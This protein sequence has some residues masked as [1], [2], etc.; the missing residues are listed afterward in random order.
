MTGPMSLQAHAFDT[1]IDAWVES[2]VAKCGANFGELLR[3]LP[4]IYPTAVI[5][6]LRRLRDQGRAS[7]AVVNALQHQAVTGERTATR[8]PVDGLPL[9]HPL[10]YEWRFTARSAQRLLHLAEEFSRPGDTVLL[11]GTPGVAAYA[12]TQTIGRRLLFLGE[13]NPVTAAVR[14]LSLRA[15]GA[16]SVQFCDMGAIAPEPATVVVIDPP[17]YLDFIRPILA[18]AAAGCRPGGHVFLSL[19]PEGTRATAVND[20]GKAIKY[21]ERLG[22]TSVG[23]ERSGLTY[24]S[25]FF[26]RN[27][28]AAAGVKGAPPDW[29]CGDLV[30]LRKAH[31]RAVQV[32]AHLVNKQR[33]RE[34]AIESMRLLVRMDHP[35]EL[36]GKWELRPVVMGEVLPTVSRRDPRRRRAT[37][38]TSGNRAFTT[39][40]PDLVLRAAETLAVAHKK[41]GAQA[42]SVVS[43]A[44]RNAIEA[45]ARELRRIV[46][47]EDR[48]ARSVANQGDRTCGPGWRSISG[49]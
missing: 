4:G 32:H 35:F 17:W 41:S 8:C 21:A 16:M 48:E 42:S 5:A 39:F 23:S 10:N 46:D 19:P 9:P 2:E 43:M 7:P 15:G 20:C 30:I 24:A 36:T 1:R 12:T 11:L 33:W 3:K 6:S 34:I 25:P 49:A 28:L 38:W 44:E 29:R 47:A 27:A 45:L 18:A 40:R 13:R 14:S 31:D 22:L 37:I 26:E